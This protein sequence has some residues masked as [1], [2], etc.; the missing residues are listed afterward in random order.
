[1]AVKITSASQALFMAIEMEKRAVSLYERMLILFASSE[2]QALLEHLLA[3]EKRHLI[4]FEH[5]LDEQSQSLEN[6]MLL[7]AL[8]DEVLF[9]GGLNRMLREGVLESNQSL[10]DYAAQEEQKAIDT[11]TSYAELCEGDAKEAFLQIAAEEKTHLKVLEKM[12]NEKG[13][14]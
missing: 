3:D 13:N 5:H 12:M 10:L 9:E 8:A 4:Q 2:N 7:S 11:Y 14:L 1:M 6:T